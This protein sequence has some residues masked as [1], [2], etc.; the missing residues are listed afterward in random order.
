MLFPYGRPARRWGGCCSTRTAGRLLPFVFALLAAVRLLFPQTA[1]TPLTVEKIYAHGPLIGNLP[2]GIAWSPDSKH[3]TYLDGGELIDLDPQSGKSHV[4]VSRA[5]LNALGGS[6]GS[7]QDRDHRERYHMPAYL[8]A[9]DSNRLLFDANGRLWYYDLKTG[10]GIQV[11][12]SG[13]GPAT[14]PSFPLTAG[15]FFYPR[16][17]PFSCASTIPPVHVANGRATRQWRLQRRSG[18]GLRRRI[19]CAQQLFL[20]AGLKEH[21]LPA[22]ERVAGAG[23]S[24]GRPHPG[25]RQIRPAALSPARRP[26]SRRACG[27]GQRRR[28]QNS[29][30]HIPLRP[31]NDYIPRFGW[32]DHAP[33]GWKRSR[34]IRSPQPL[35]RRHRLRAGPPGSRTH[36]RTSFST[37]TT[38]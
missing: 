2:A 36:R 19:G 22:N 4:L 34:G 27:R 16:S 25:A 17:Q 5:K 37:K 13:Q 18:L 35:L 23:V 29:W 31:G 14:T 32:V 24:A 1:P 38:T 21:R 7:E 20:V 30:M 6:G 33:S 26:Q 15:A 10:N 3:L 8:W 9:P 28:R 12:F 11:A